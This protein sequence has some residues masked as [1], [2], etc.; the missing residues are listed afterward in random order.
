[1]SRLKKEKDGDEA[2]SADKVDEE[3]AA[4]NPR[5][6]FTKAVS[7]V[8]GRCIHE[9]MGHMGHSSEEESQQLTTDTDFDN[10]FASVQGNGT[11]SVE[12]QGRQPK[13]P[14][15]VN[16]NKAALQKAAWKKSQKERKSTAKHNKSNPGQHQAAQGDKAKG[17]GKGKGKDQAKAKGKG[18]DA[19]KASGKGGSAK[20]KAGKASSKGVSKGDPKGKAKGKADRGSK[21]K[22]KGK[23]N[24]G[25]KGGF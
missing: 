18:K 23:D 7:V 13:S 6:L 12:G 1:M 3:V 19:S 14:P 20:A 21:P 2:A 4:A 11:A 16:G 15:P 5:E 24:G 17:K 10:F 8:A 9:V 22:G 25:K